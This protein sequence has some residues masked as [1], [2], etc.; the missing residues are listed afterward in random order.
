[1]GFYL[2]DYEIECINHE[3]QICGKRKISFEELLK[4]YLNHAPSKAIQQH[5]ID[6]AIRNLLDL[7][8]ISSREALVDRKSL[9]EILTCGDGDKTSVENA[10]LYLKELLGNSSQVFLKDFLKNVLKLDE[11]V[12]N[13]VQ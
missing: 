13:T 5:D 3:L 8:D 7:H 6:E 11:N 12:E 1:M 2:S 9:V 10:E 4:L